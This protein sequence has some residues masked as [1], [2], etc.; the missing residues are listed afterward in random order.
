LDVTRFHAAYCW[1]SQSSEITVGV[2]V[3]M[4]AL[5]EGR[6]TITNTD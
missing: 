5:H 1:V 4:Q 2:S 6:G 3:I